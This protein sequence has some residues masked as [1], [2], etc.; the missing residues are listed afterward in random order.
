M[1]QEIIFT[2]LP[3]MRTE[4]NGEPFLKLSVYTTIK[5]STPNDTTLAAFEDILSYAQKVANA[6]FRFRLNNGNLLDAQLISEKIDPE[7]YEHIF[8]SEIKVDDFK[9]EDLSAKNIHSVPLKHINDFVLKNYREIAITQPKQMVSADKFIDETRFGAISRMKLDVTNL[10]KVNA[11]QR[12][13][14]LKAEQLF[15]K[16]DNDDRV[17]RSDLRQQKFMRFAPQM[18]PKTDFAQLRQFHKV[19]K[20]II[21]RISS[22]KLQK[23]RFEFHDILSVINSYPELMRKLGFVLDFLVPYNASIPDTGNISLDI[24]AM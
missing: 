5:L 9:D 18:N 13:T 23:P 17:F 7:L 2:T 11:P 20:K 6:S 10:E 15:F 4:I 8:H 22:V 3:H 14:V 1:A 21:S 24:S 12:T 16:N 19:D